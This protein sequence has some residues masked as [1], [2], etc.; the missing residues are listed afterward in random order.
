MSTQ[1]LI[2]L[3]YDTKSGGGGKKWK[4]VKTH[5]NNLVTSVHQLQL[6]ITRIKY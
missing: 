6:L 2:P 5:E 3:P 4:S 1:K